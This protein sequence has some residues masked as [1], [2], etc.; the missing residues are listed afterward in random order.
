MFRTMEHDPA[1]PAYSG[2]L[3]DDGDDKGGLGEGA[4]VHTAG[5]RDGDGLVNESKIESASATC[6]LWS[7]VGV[8][9]LIGGRPKSSVSQPRACCRGLFDPQ[10]GGRGEECRRLA[11]H[12]G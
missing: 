8:G 2:G 4:M 12:R 9:C 7:T 3:S 5:V 11:V 10:L 6:I 1:F